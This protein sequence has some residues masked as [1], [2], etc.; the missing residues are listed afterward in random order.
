MNRLH[1]LLLERQWI[2]YLP[3]RR[4]DE[5]TAE[6]GL[7]PAHAETNSRFWYRH[8]IEEDSIG[9]A[10]GRKLFGACQRL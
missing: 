4:V 9:S 2:D 8:D 10:H 3:I 7:E 1:D 6:F 5:W